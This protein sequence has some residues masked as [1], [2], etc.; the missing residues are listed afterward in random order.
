MYYGTPTR[1]FTLF[2]LLICLTIV[3]ILI[4]TGVPGMFNLKA[5][6]E[7]R[8][9]TSSIRKMLIVARQYAVAENRRITLCGID[10]REHCNN[11]NFRHI[12]VFFD[13]NSNHLLDGPD[14]IIAISGLNYSGE[15]TLRASLRS[16]HISFNGDGSATRAGSFV[17]C[18]PVYANAS[19][20]ITVSMSGRTYMASD[21]NND[22]I[23][24]LTSGN[25]IRC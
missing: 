21:R 7:S 16:Q 9:L 19:A 18:N 12:A 2:E 3:T 24:A 8:A 15:L 20:R 14:K 5:Q 11:E 6:Y 1:G 13:H 22:G 17:F 10:A 4:G 23:V 25:P